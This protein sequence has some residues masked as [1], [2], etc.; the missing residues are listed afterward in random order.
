MS[1][2]VWDQT[3]K[4][5]YETGVD[6]GVLFLLDEKGDYTIAEAWNGLTAV[7]HSPEG[8]EAT[9]LYANNKKYLDLMSN[10][11]FN[12]SIEAYT[13]P[14]G[15]KACNGEVEL[16]PGMIVSQ[17]VR[18]TFG[19]VHRTLLGN[20]TK[21]NDYGYK[22]HLIYGSKAAPSEKAYATVNDDPEAMTL[23]WECSTTP[24]DVEGAKPTAHVEID[25]TKVDAAKLAELEAIL[26]GSD[27]AEPRLPL[28]AEVA[29]IL[30]AAA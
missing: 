28:P 21:G 22:L 19:L 15:F 30:T 6:K 3:G 16:A 24:V 10:E 1:K 25:S 11:D 8:A 4:R 14:D 5:L 13:Y 7:N 27:D 18:A 29:E 23:S 12:Y 17:Q 26:F 9:P 2:L 20:D